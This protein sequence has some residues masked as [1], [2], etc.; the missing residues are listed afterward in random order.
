MH[1]R[2]SHRESAVN[3]LIRSVH[4]NGP[5]GAVLTD[6]GHPIGRREG[7]IAIVDFSGSRPRP[8]QWHCRAS[9]WRV[10]PDDNRQ[11]SYTGMGVTL[12]VGAAVARMVRQRGT[13]T[14]QNRHG[15]SDIGGV[16][17][18]RNQRVTPADIVFRLT[19]GFRPPCQIR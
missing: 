12:A 10:I 2:R 6:R 18:D 19:I 1:G 7:E 15:R 5:V 14:D 9:A 16:F 8:V 13:A 4:R 3:L 17:T 11:N